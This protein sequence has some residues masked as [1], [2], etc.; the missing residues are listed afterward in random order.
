MRDDLLLYYKDELSYLRE[1]GAQ[2]AQDYPKIASRLLLEPDKCE[3]PHVERLLEGVAFL[4]AR[5]HLKIDDE[6]PQITEGLLNIIY[7]HFLRPIP[8]MSIAEF[9]IDP[10]QGKITDGYTIPRE[11]VLLSR[12]VAR[13]PC[14]FKT[15][16]PTTLWPIHISGAQFT[17]SDKL[18]RT[19]AAAD[20]PGAIRVEIGCVG[21][22]RLADLQMD[23]LRFYLNGE[24]RVVHRL[25]ERLASKVLRIVLRDTTPGSTLAPVVL[26]TSALRP[27]GFRE[28]EGVVPYPR[29]SFVGYRLLQEYFAF[30]QKFLFF[31]VS[32][33]RAAWGTGFGKQAEIV[34]MLS[35][36]VSQ[37]QREI[38]ERGVSGRTFRLGCTPIINL[39]EQP[40]EGILLDQRKYEYPVIPDVSRPN[41]T[42]VFSV[43]EVIG[44][45]L[46]TR[47][48]TH[49]RPFYAF[50][51]GGE[52]EGREAFWIANRRPSP[53]AD[54]SGTDLFISLLDLSMHPVDPDADQ[55]N[56]QTTCT[57]R[58]LPA[59]LPF[60]NE[61]GDFQLEGANPLKRI[62]ALLKPT[63]PIRPPIGKGAHWRL[64][65]HL[66]LNYLSLVE[67]GRDALL[68][69]LKLYNFTDSADI[70]KAIEGITRVSSR[71]QF[72]ALVSDEGVAFARGSR[73]EIEFDEAEFEGGGVY[74][75][76]A[77]LEHFLGLYA[78]INSF[79]QLKATT[80]QRKDEVWEWVPRAGR[81]ILV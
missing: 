14:K 47:K 22:V 29:Q 73:V 62:V 27:V 4:A 31:E 57:N 12:P 40:A 64:I 25:Y 76:A 43:D 48:E 78:S 41:G 15:A 69:I 18:H 58:D 28:D 75:F 38:L 54:D 36:P 2:F 20:S 34:F 53:R 3:D 77:V 51:F 74:L 52:A 11:A 35:S 63:A 8:S 33:L 71:R 1:M 44:L 17:T 80:K 56:I 50:R 10:E 26:P 21:E 61:S 55:L 59:R 6:F 45:N 79:T 66:S 72:S 5:V 32:G 9:H 7:P 81:R 46:Q 42:E 30:P 65:S 49:Y 13:V 67:N 70:R 16:Y 37:D 39:F 24:G 68:E 23:Q 19:I 60:G